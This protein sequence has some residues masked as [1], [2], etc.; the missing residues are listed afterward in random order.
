[1]GGKL[2]VESPCGPVGLSRKSSA[3]VLAL[4]R[5]RASIDDAVNSSEVRVEDGNADDVN[6]VLLLLVVWEANFEVSNG[7]EVVVVRAEG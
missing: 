2:L 1:M 5:L 3:M 4:V 6:E 7:S